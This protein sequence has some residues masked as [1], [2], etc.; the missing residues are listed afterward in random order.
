VNTGAGVSLFKKLQ[1]LPVPCQHIFSIM[2]FPVSNEEHFEIHLYAVLIKGISS[3][4]TD[5]IPTFH[6]FRKVHS[7]LAL[8]F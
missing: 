8:A 7:M 1:I 2:N 4:F 6:V 3:I 5:K